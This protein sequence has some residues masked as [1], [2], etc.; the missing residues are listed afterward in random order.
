VALDRLDGYPWPGNLDELDAVVREAFERS[1]G[2]EILPS[3]L[4]K[5]IELGVRRGGSP[6]R[7]EERIVVD[8]FLAQ[9]ERELIERSLAQP[10]AI[11][12]R[13]RGF[14]AFTRPRL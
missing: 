6:R 11:R 7:R 4:P 1:S 5:R 8:D 10:R 2:P 9:V 14:S 13:R 12:P 3:D